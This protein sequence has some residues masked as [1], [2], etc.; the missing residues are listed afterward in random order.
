M[1]KAPTN[2]RSST[3]ESAVS[4][5]QRPVSRAS[6][7]S[8]QTLNEE[9]AEHPHHVSETGPTAYDFSN[10]QY[11]PKH[12]PE[13]IIGYSREHLIDPHRQGSID[14]SVHVPATQHGKQVHS[15]MGQFDGAQSSRPSQEPHMFFQDK[16][17]TPF[18]AADI[19]QTQDDFVQAD[20]Q[21]KKGS[22]ASIANDQE[23]RRLYQENK[24][25]SLGELADA[26][27]A[28]ERG[29]RSEKTKQIFA[30]IWYG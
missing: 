19:D 4:N 12:T 20:Q 21:K 13:E 17:D 23:L 7:T 8:V 2:V 16:E 29:P 9:S 10:T 11:N 30:M 1:G 24:H 5:Q 3:T 15:A 26:V 25:R 18:T 22:G 28:E 27:L 14:P 6:T